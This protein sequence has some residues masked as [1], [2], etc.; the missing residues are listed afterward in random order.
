MLTFFLTV[1]NEILWRP[2]F[3]A[4][5]FLYNIL[6]V[7]DLGL[8][9][10]ILTIVVRLF[11][12][13]FLWKA[14]KNQ[15]DLAK[16]QP[17]IKKIQEKFKD[18]REAQTKALMEF[19]A[20]RKIN[21]F[22]GCLVILV[23]IPVLIAL[24]QVFRHGFEVSQLKYLYTF[25]ANPGRLDPVSF[26]IIDLSRGNIYLGI[27]AA[28]AQYYQIKLSA[29]NTYT[30]GSAVKKGDFSAI[31]QK[32][33]IYVFPLLILMWSYTLPSALILYWTVINLIGVL[34]EIILKRPDF[35]KQWIPRL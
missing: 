22:S 7:H 21:P 23:Q 19:Y 2:L 26:G 28:I 17:E 6:P 10:I 3:N 1:Y 12:A 25:V 33:M 9:I 13:P 27:V 29:S 16:L 30:D 34:Q 18:N 11:L 15:Q 35:I 20:A 24:F 31:M 5:V 8:A 14:R 4:L 32:Q